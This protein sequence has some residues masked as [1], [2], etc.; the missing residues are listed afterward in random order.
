MVP[1]TFQPSSFLVVPQNNPK[2][3][4]ILPIKVLDGLRTAPPETDFAHCKG[5]RSQQVADMKSCH[6]VA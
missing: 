1:T 3:D 6:P 2:T 4:T 5:H